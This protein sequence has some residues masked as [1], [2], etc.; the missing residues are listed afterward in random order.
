MNKVE[1]MFQDRA[2]IRHKGLIVYQKK[3]AIDF[4]SSL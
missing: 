3:D 2:I 1:E 4:G